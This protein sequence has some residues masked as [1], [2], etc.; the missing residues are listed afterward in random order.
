M[1][2]VG[3]KVTVINIRG[4]EYPYKVTQVEKVLK[5]KIVAGGIDFDLNGWEKRNKSDRW[6]WSTY[7]LVPYLPEHSVKIKRKNLQRRLEKLNMDN[8]PDETIFKLYEELKEYI[9]D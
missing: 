8:L 7:K 5:T 2:N 6:S 3:D 9:D 4:E 1:F